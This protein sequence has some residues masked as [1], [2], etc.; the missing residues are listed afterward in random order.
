M[1]DPTASGED[2]FLGVRRSLRGRFWRLN[3]ADAALVSTLIRRFGL[4]EVVARAMA[5]RGIGEAAA[6]AY[7]SPTLRT[8]LP[9]PSRLADMDRAVAR[10]AAAVA[11]AEPLAVFGD[12]DVDGATSAALMVRYFRALGM[13]VAVHI[14]DRITEGYGPNAAAILGLRDRGARLLVT[15]DCGV[16]AF[17]ALE[18]ARDAGMEVIVVDHHQVEEALPAAFAV[19]DPKRRDDA[20]GAEALAAVGVTF[21]LLVGLNRALRAAGRFSAGRPEPDLMRMLDL[22]AFGTVCDVVPL[23]GINRAFVAQGLKVLA[24]GGN[25]GLAAL[26]EMAGVTTPETYH[27]G[28][29]LGPRINAGGRVG[30]SD[31]GVRLLSCDDPAE[32]RALAAELEEHNV[33]RREI[34]AAA[35]DEAVAQVE[36]TLPPDSPVV[37]AAGE[38]WHPGVVG[39]VA[40]RLKERFNVPA[41][42]VTFLGEHGKG[43]GRSVPGVNLGAA[44]LAAREAGVLL[45]GGGH[46]MAAGF[47]IMRSELSRFCT[48]LA[49]HV[50]AQRAGGEAVTV[51]PVD[52]AIDVRGAVPELVSVLARME[53]F[54][55]G[56]DEPRFAVPAVRLG[57][58]EIVGSSH[59]RAHAYGKNGGRLKIIAFRAAEEELGR[60]LLAHRDRPLHLLGALR[61][62]TWQGRNEVQL[63]VEDAAWADEEPA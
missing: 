25:T 46:A 45:T 34:E 33:S 54:G 63:V 35:L 50:R 52:G 36:A 23:T 55:A 20:S 13:P 1:A 37:V 16:T 18:A 38:D 48:F 24:A 8:L 29:V 57:R 44:V 14:P 5:A 30:T 7:L 31:L 58:A 51:V 41:C 42:A 6:E 4:P 62:D 43:S 39:L 10:L 40:A 32:A 11:A 26:A 28:F 3:P 2:A 17:A 15:V 56:N 19:V 61:A 12:Y 21:L 9:D 59:V 49:D 60:A 53:P 22:V 27:I 47:T